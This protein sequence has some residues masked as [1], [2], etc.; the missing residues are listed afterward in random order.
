MKYKSELIE[1]LQSLYDNDQLKTD[2]RVT[3]WS[4]LE[5]VIGYNDIETLLKYSK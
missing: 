1:E 5:E 3:I 4:V 2:Y